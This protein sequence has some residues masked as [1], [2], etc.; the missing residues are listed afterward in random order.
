MGEGKAKEERDRMFQEHKTNG[1]V[2]DKWTS[3]DVQKMIYSN[4]CVE[5][6]NAEFDTFYAR[7]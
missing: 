4:D 3:P 2:P 7:L 5:K 1:S 6:V